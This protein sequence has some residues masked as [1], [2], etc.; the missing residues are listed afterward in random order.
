[1]N[2]LVSLLSV[3]AALAAVG[4]A[5]WQIRRSAR[6]SENANALPIIAALFNEMR[7]REF[8]QHMK[9]VATESPG[10]PPDEGFE[11]LPDEWRNSAYAV[12]YF[13]DYLGVLAANKIVDEKLII[14]AT[15]TTIARMWEVLLPYIESERAWR[16]KTYNGAASPGFLRYF[17][18]LVARN[19]DLGGRDAPREIQRG[20]DL[21]SLPRT[22]AGLPVRQSRGGG[23]YQAD[24]MY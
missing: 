13:Y 14:G 19:L 2:Q 23:D 6:M 21:R 1:M 7:S 18:H 16:L 8:R 20:I 5:V 17:E 11:G 24:A 12:S 4:V 15:G 22:A 10:D 3:L 9:R